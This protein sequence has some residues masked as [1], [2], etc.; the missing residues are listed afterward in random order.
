MNLEQRTRNSNRNGTK[1]YSPIN[2]KIKFNVQNVPV[3]GSCFYWSVLVAGGYRVSPQEVMRLRKEVSR[4]LQYWFTQELHYNLNKMLTNP[5]G[6]NVSVRQY[7]NNT[8]KY[9]SWAGKRE[10]QAVSYILGRRIYSIGKDF[11]FLPKFSYSGDDIPAKNPI[12]ILY[13]GSTHFQPLL[14]KHRR[15]TRRKFPII[16]HKYYVPPK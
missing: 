9:S 1:N 7:I 12:Y 15:L 6:Q 10:I 16:F 5:Q 3:T 4:V 11:K 14:L 8:R 2:F 13:N